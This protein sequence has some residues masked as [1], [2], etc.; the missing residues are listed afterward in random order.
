MRVKHYKYQLSTLYVLLITLTLYLLPNTIQAQDW[1]WIN[2]GGSTDNI[3][4]PNSIDEMT[5]YIVTDSQRN[6]YAIAPVGY[7]GLN[8]DGNAK[9]NWDNYGGVEDYALF[10]FTC[11]GAYRWSKLLVAKVLKILEV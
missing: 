7:A 8:I 9:Q 3:N 10:S 2:S 4:P 5:E 1:Q 11:D 6:I